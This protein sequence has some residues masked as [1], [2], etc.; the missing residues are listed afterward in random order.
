MGRKI[1]ILGFLTV[2]CGTIIKIFMTHGIKGVI[3]MGIFLMAVG[4]LMARSDFE[5]SF[6]EDDE[7]DED[8]FWED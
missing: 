7:D 3:A 8:D 6:N 1:K 2:Y 4:T 5:L